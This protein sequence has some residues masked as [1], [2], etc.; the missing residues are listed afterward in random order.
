MP[1]DI[2]RD[3]LRRQAANADI[4]VGDKGK[5]ALRRTL[6]EHADS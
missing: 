4:P 1:Q 6:D 3:E 2:T 5:E